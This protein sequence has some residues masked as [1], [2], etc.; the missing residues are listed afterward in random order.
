MKNMAKANNMPEVF[1]IAGPNGAGKTTVAMSL[2]PDLLECMEYVNADSI[3]TG[4]SPFQPDSVVIE[5]GKLM[6]QRINKLAAENKSFA[7]ETTLASKNFARLLKQW[8][9][10]G[11]KIN[12]I[13]VWLKNSALAIDRVKER[14]LSGGHSIPE[15]T[16]KRRYYR[17]ICNLFE[18]YLPVV[19]NA[20]IF[21]NSYGQ[22][23]VVAQKESSGEL[24]VLDQS[25]W[26]L[27]KDICFDN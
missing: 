1:I 18:L 9:G 23:R 20:C 22:S 7:F 13:Y 5:A 11:Y 24:E 19:D 10:I 3:A 17:S 21:D 12:L 25:A 2:F 14:V 26:D 27:I 8:K 6:L 16:I 15:D 4:L